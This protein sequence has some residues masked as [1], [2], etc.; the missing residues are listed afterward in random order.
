MAPGR[1]QVVIVGGGPA[2]AST[3]IFAARRGLEVVVLEAHAVALPKPG[4]CLPPAANPVLREMGLSDRLRRDGHLPSY[5]NRS[6]WGTVVPIERDFLFGVHGPGWHLDRRKFESLLA[7]TAREAGADWR[8]RHRLE[9]CFRRGRAWEVT[10]RTPRGV[11]V[12]KADFVVD[13]TGR[14]SRLARA[15]GVR[16]TRY[17]RLVGVTAVLRNSGPGLGDSF[18]LVETVP[19]GWWYSAPVPGGG[20]AVAFMTDGDRLDRVGVRDP[21]GWHALVRQSGPTHDRV[22]TGAYGLSAPPHVAPAN[23]SRL[24]L[25]AG[26]GWLAVGDA[27]AA[28]DPLSSY[29]ICSALGTGFHA[30]E[31]IA[32]AAAGRPSALGEY[33][34]L[35]DRAWACY[36]AKYREHYESERRWPEEPFWRR[37]HGPA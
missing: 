11:K 23:T 21:G 27:A 35:I 22:R 32:E 16:R 6:V 30:A 24:T 15:L 37:R 20:L 13:A 29:G 26:E 18:T 28:F 33:A 25:A 34:C 3:A 12:L 7:E 8:Y 9:G 31:A 2:G 36:V 17:D 10:V 14:S 1:T 4:E 19:A 5:G